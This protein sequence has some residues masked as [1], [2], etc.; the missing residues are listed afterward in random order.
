MLPSCDRVDLPI[1]L[2]LRAM[3][4]ELSRFITMLL[5]SVSPIDRATE[6]LSCTVF[7][8]ATIT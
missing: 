5:A 1:S 8:A 2:C 7:M 6:L 3:L 4:V